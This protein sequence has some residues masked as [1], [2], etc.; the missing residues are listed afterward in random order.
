MND[1]ASSLQYLLACSET[2]LESFE[3]S[4]LNRA[5]NL[6]KELSQVAEEWVDAEVSS[7]LARLI[8]ERRRAD[9][10]PSEPRLERSARL[11]SRD[12]ST[13]CLLFAS[14]PD[15][16][17]T[18]TKPVKLGLKPPCQ[19]AKNQ[20]RASARSNDHSTGANK[21][22]RGTKEA[23]RPQIGE[24][25][26]TANS[27]FA[28]APAIQGTFSRRIAKSIQAATSL[29]AL[30]VIASGP[31]VPHPN[32]PTTTATCPFYFRLRRHAGAP[33]L[34]PQSIP[35]NQRAAAMWQFLRPLHASRAGKMF[36]GLIERGR[37]A[38]SAS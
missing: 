38:L 16:A 9:L 11:T 1:T 29:S 36:P 13:L 37:S 10:F 18:E 20:R 28:A 24:A 4:R 27:F 14:E 17:D 12:R 31:P 15:A 8:V 35:M 19:R 6:R 22:I 32:L 25:S 30:D 34:P 3:L 2:S 7:R 5:S 33:K 21:K 23:P 26:Q